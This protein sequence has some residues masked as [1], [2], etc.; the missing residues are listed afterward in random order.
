MVGTPDRDFS[1]KSEEER[2]IE[3]TIELFDHK[4]NP[5]AKLKDTDDIYYQEK[6]KITVKPDRKIEKK[7][8]F[9]NIKDSK[10]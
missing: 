8:L 4:N 7:V 10:G 3:Y 6:F 2:T 9:L 1:L 5:I